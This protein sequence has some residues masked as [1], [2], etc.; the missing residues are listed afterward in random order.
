MTT[1]KI[2]YLFWFTA[3]V[4]VLA[5]GPAIA[6]TPFPTT[7]PN[8][9]STI[10]AQTAFAASTQ[11]AA[12]IPTSTF[13]LTPSPTRPTPTFSPT[14]TSTVIFI[15][16]TPTP[17]VIPTFTFLSNGNGNGGSGSGSSSSSANYA[18]QIL[19]VSPPNGTKFDPRADFDAVWSV[20]NIGQEPWDRNSVDFVYD[21]GS[22]LHKV[23][24]YDLNSDVKVGATTN[25]GVDME[26]PKDSGTYTT[27]WTL[28]VGSNDFCK[29]SLT[30]NVK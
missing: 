24:G 20:K 5:C 18:C 8:E 14:P 26:T 10:I 9:I 4:I 6:T 3:L 2:K 19:S 12:A 25:L 11:T 1:S 15:L 28:R 16:S 7:D 29:M 27:T 17:F 23:A 21:S 13:T 30:I 22:K